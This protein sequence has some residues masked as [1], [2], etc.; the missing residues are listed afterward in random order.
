MLVIRRIEKEK[1][2]EEEEEERKKEEKKKEEE[3]ENNEIENQIVNIEKIIK[4]IERIILK[5]GEYAHSHYIIN[6]FCSYCNKLLIDDQDY[7]LSICYGYTKIDI[8]LRNVNA[9][10]YFSVKLIKKKEKKTELKN[11]LI[12]NM[13]EKFENIKVLREFKKNCYDISME[14]MKQ[15]GENFDSFVISPFIINQFVKCIE[16]LII[17]KNYISF[18]NDYII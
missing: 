8:V 3:E 14:L 4:K 15:R 2:K 6:N 10:D 16:K 7:Y 12:M 18:D 11:L 13:I 1:K 17:S 9:K 5:N